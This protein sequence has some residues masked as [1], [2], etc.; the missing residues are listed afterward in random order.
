MGKP[1]RNDRETY[2]YNDSGS[3]EVTQQIMDSYNSGVID[4]TSGEAEISLRS[5]E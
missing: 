1:K 5:E 2:T 4:P 3:L